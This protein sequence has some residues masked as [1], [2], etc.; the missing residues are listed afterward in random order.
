MIRV[1]AAL[2]V[3]DG[4]VLCAQ[5]PVDK[6]EGGL[7]EFP[8]GK[9]EVD[10]SPEQALKR[11]IQEELDVDINV[12]AWHQQVLHP[13]QSKIVLDFYWAEIESGEL[14]ALE[15]QAIR[16]CE[17]TELSTLEWAPADIPVVN[18]LSQLSHFVAPLAL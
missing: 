4:K 15:H 1:V 6:Q 5:R 17:P 12:L 16:W 7:W 8:G 18:S 14:V 9:I 11:E 3:R 10:E 13:R 2:I